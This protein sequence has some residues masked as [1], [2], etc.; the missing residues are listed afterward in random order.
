MAAKEASVLRHTVAWSAATI[1]GLGVLGLSAGGQT[2]G[3]GT[4]LSGTTR[5]AS[6][7]PLE[8]VAVSARAVTSTFTTTVYTDEKGEYFFPPL[9]SG[10]HGV[11]AQATGYATARA[12]AMLEPARSTRSAFT[13]NPIQD[14]TLQL[15]GP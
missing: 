15:R 14:S 5:M 6:G 11:W 2:S 13:L 1:F 9:E 3:S 4:P 8:G 10:K 12:E 7:T